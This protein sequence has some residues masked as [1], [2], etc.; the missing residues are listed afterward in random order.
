[1]V[2]QLEHY[3]AFESTRIHG[4][5]ADIL[6][7]TRHHEFWSTDLEMLHA[8]GIRRLR[9]SAPWHKIEP[10]PN[11]FDFSWLD[12]PLCFMRQAGMSPVLDPLHH[13]SFPDWLVGG[14][15][16]PHFPDVYR[17]FIEK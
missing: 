4:C 6:D 15:A 13:T 16:N 14:F 9:Y 7:T 10:H 8:A 12:Q 17:R 5:S 3:G 1:M 11:V 2:R